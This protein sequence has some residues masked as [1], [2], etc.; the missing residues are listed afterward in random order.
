MLYQFLKLN[1]YYLHNKTL[2]CHLFGDLKQEK[3]MS[4][5]LLLCFGL[6]LVRLSYLSDHLLSDYFLC[7]LFVSY[8]FTD[9]SAIYPLVWKIV[10]ES[11]V[12]HLTLEVLCYKFQLRSI[13]MKVVDPPL[14]EFYLMCVCTAFLKCI[15]NYRGAKSQHLH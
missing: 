15:L 5:F 3:K 9:I 6:N 13:L 4:L 1:S 14:Q 2:Q 7:I 10:T 11:R 12:V 8:F